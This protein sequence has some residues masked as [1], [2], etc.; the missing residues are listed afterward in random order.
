MHITSDPVATAATMTPSG[1]APELLDQLYAQVEMAWMQRRAARLVDQLATRYPEHKDE[2]YDFLALLVDSELGEPLSKEEA[3]QSVERTKEWLAG[4]G[5]K[6]A[7]QAA[8]DMRP[9]DAATDPTDP[10][11]NVGSVAAGS[12][13]PGCDSASEHEGTLPFGFM[14][15][16]Q[17]RTN[18]PPL[19]LLDEIDV[20]DFILTFAQ[21]NP[22]GET[23]EGAR[24]EIVRRARK[25]GW[26][27]EGEGE[28]ELN[29][30][31]CKAAFKRTP[32]VH[33]RPEGAEN[34]GRSRF[35]HYVDVIRTSR[36]KKAKKQY[37]LA[38]AEEEG[39][40]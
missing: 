1:D 16:L 5:C 39:K 25:K 14:G 19:Q 12:A 13:S 17:L 15:L 21:D 22:P 8:K 29:R 30:V 7:A 23:P 4:E 26:I 11:D 36:L 40:G 18:Q 24:K 35:P 31:V 32:Y 33:N 28:E 10:Q 3:L 20:P 34:V 6:L 27:Q 9:H 2:L 38:F 37:W